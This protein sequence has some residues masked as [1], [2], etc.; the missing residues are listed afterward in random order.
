MKFLRFVVLPLSLLSGFAVQAHAEDKTEPTPTVKPGFAPMS[1]PFF[2]GAIELR[3]VMGNDKI[4]MH[5]QPKT[6]DR[7]S[8]EGS[9]VVAGG[10]RNQGKKI[11][12]AGEVS[13]NK[14]SMEESEDGVD[15]SGQWDG[16]LKDNVIR[17]VWQSDDGKVSKDFVLELWLAPKTKKIKSPSSK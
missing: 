16:E 6:E 14:L 15:V 2:A 8:V 12:L 3:G 17:G 10:K 1:N 4:R 7:D 9:Y 5:L 13:K 11:L